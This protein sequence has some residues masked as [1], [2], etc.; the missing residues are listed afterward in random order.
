VTEAQLRSDQDYSIMSDDLI[1]V[2]AAVELG[3]KVGM[4]GGL[5]VCGGGLGVCVVATAAG[6]AATSA[7]VRKKEEQWQP[8]HGSQCS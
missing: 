4:C 5:G 7:A 6:I 1:M 2:H 8:T 3:R